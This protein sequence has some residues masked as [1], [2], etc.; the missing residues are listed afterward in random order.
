MVNKDFFSALA[1]IERDNK[2]PKG[3]LIESLE[4]GL[5]SAFR[6]ET[7]ECRAITAKLNEERGIIEFFAYQTVV[8]GEPTDETELSLEE[9]QDVKPDAK[10]GEVIG[11]DIS[12][13]DFSR[14]AAQT[15]K[16]LI[17]LKISEAKKEQA[18]L[19]MSSREGELILSIVRRVDALNI[20]VEIGGTQMEGILSSSDRIPNEKLKVGD[21]VKVYIKKVREGHRGTHISVSR[22]CAG[23][24]RRL[25]DMEVPELRTNLVK[26]KNIV[27]EAGHRTK[28]AVFSD[29]PNIDAIGAC[30]GPKGTRINAIINELS[31]EKVDLILYCADPSEYIARALSPAKVLMVQLNETDKVAK[32]VVPDDKLSLAIGRN[33]QNARL[34]AKLTG[35]KIDVKPYSAI[36]EPTYYGDDY[37]DEDQTNQSDG[38]STAEFDSNTEGPE[39]DPES[40]DLQPLEDFEYS[41]DLEGYLD[42][43]DPTTLADFPVGL[44]DSLNY[45]DDN[46]NDLNEG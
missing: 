26:V 32:V 1:Q 37:V 3:T 10:I 45:V 23:F 22:S 30:I 13:K 27:R 2:I 44:D 25:F 36:M 18:R 7:G 43:L 34:A 19:D 40:D 20:Y 16:Q 24:V 8:D 42:N 31:G 21:K 29:D 33:G 46:S 5:A 12:P 28:M 38:N 11:E 17:L 35:F 15:A 9:A 4:A 39:F 6:K 41:E 14:I